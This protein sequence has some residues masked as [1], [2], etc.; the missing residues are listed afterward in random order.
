MRL[1]N[2]LNDPAENQDLSLEYPELREEM[3]V[4]Y[5]T[6]A[7]EVG[8]LE[9]PADFNLNSQLADNVL[10]K[11][12][13]NNALLIVLIGCALLATLVLIGYGIYRTFGRSRQVSGIDRPD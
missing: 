4:D 13:E 12:I 11:L 8:V 6:Y 3:L 9:L 10:A 2:L 5:K 7:A 1:H